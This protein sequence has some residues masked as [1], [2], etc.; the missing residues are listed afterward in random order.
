[1]CVNKRQSSKPERYLAL[2][3]LQ[4][5]NILIKYAKTDMLFFR[6]AEQWL[7]IYKSN[8]MFIVNY[9]ELPNFICNFVLQLLNSLSILEQIRTTILCK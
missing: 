3:V 8:M 2:A 7:P 9:P 6:N 1:M 5:L 4:Y